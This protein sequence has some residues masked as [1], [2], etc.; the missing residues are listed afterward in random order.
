MALALDEQKESD[1][2]HETGGFQFLV[3]KALMETAA[4]I[5]VDMNHMGF[6]VH[7]SLKLDADGGCSSC[8]A[9]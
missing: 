1:T 9:C 5:T 6:V 4:P 7:S 8:S 3:D 2:V